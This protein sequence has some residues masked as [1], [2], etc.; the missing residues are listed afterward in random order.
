MAHFFCFKENLTNILQKSSLVL[1]NITNIV[2]NCTCA[3]SPA[4]IN[5]LS[6]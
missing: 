2:Q 3:G 5:T 4:G 1:Y 6:N